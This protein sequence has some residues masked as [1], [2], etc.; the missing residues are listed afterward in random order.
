M[1]GEKHACPIC[2]AALEPVV[3]NVKEKMITLSCPGF[4]AGDTSHANIVRKITRDDML[5]L[6][7]SDLFK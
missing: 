2:K 7:D 5:E 6:V 3:I 1:A 4:I